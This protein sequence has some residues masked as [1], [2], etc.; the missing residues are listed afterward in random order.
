M[1]RNAHLSPKKLIVVNANKNNSFM[2]GH[3]SWSLFTSGMFQ[4]MY[5]NIMNICVTIFKFHKINSKYILSS[6]N[7]RIAKIEYELFF[8]NFTYLKTFYTMNWVP[9]QAPIFECNDGTKDGTTLYEMKCVITATKCLKIDFQRIF[10]TYDKLH[11]N[12]CIFVV[13]DL[14]N[15]EIMHLSYSY[16][17]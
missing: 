5:F 14:E 15:D 17:F 1:C 9:C 2:C 16:K 3:I 8:T 13:V 6:T 7:L 4:N 11:L 10:Y 12:W